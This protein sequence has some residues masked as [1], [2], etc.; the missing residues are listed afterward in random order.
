MALYRELLQRIYSDREIQCWLIWTQTG[1]IDQL[2]DTA[3]SQALAAM[4]LPKVG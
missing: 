3:M 4:D 2:T 1:Q